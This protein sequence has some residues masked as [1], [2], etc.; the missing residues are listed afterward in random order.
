M[1]LEEEEPDREPWQL[2]EL[3]AFFSSPVFTEGLR[4]TAGR[5]EAAYWLP[6]LALFT[7]ARLGELAPLTV[8]D[9]TTDNPAGISTIRV[10]EHLEQGRR[11]KNVGSRRVVSIPPELVGLGFMQ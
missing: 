4:P 6:L 7:G 3:K 8:A 2:D 9:I 1:R 5:G 10:T 11:L